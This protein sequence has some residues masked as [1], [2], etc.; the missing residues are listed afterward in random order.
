MLLS[1]RGKPDAPA[2]PPF[3]QLE[4][5]RSDRPETITILLPGA[6]TTADIFR[7][8]QDWAT[9]DHLVVEFHL[10][11]KQGEPVLPPLDLDRSAGWVP[12]LANRYPDADMQLIGYSPA[13]PSPSRQPAVL[14]PLGRGA[15]DQGRNPVLSRRP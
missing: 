2:S 11:G 5:G 4:A 10:P 8:A 13:R 3:Y 6:L 1:C 15:V 7:P 14:V 12:D 9:P